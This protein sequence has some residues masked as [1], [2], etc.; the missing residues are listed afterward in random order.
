MNVLPRSTARRLRDVQNA[1]DAAAEAVT[2]ERHDTGFARQKDL[3]TVLGCG[4]ATCWGRQDVRSG[5]AG[6]SIL[7]C[8]ILTEA[9]AGAAIRPEIVEAAR[10]CKVPRLYER[11]WRGEKTGVTPE[12]VEKLVPRLVEDETLRQTDPEA[13]LQAGATAAP[14]HVDEPVKP[15]EG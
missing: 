8:P 1:A 14:V 12:D 7:C 9:E 3:S 13:A 11:V 6:E 5:P 15:A 4:C 10:D 2:Q